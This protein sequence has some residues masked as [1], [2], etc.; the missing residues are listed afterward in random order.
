M[1][2]AQFYADVGHS[3]RVIEDAA[4]KAV[5]AYRA[6]YFSILKGMQWPLNAL[7]DL[8]LR[9]DSSILATVGRPGLGLVSPRKPYRLA[10][11]LWEVPVAILQ[12]AFVHYLPLASGGGVRLVPPALLN[13]WLR[14]FERDVGPGVFYVHP[15]EFDVESPTARRLSRWPLRLGRR[16]LTRRL[17][18]LMRDIQF[19]SIEEVFAAP[20]GSSLSRL[21]ASALP[22]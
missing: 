22:H 6:P 19:G 14:R 11:G 9:Y 15:W 7:R 10:N 21:G 17:A 16:R 20:L 18:T 8:G 2:H 5:R 1:S 13:R 12:F 3:L 4:G